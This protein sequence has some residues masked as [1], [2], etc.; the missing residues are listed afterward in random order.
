MPEFYKIIARK[1][2]I[3]DF[4][5]EGGGARAPLPPVSYAYALGYT[6]LLQLCTGPQWQ[7]LLLYYIGDIYS[8][9]LWEKGFFGPSSVKRGR[10]HIVLG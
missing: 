6:R 4:L 2:Y 8:L 10:T 5:G 7:T 3:L 1:K 9:A